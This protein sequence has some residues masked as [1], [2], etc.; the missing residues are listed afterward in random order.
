MAPLFSDFDGD[1]KIDCAELSSDGRF[2]QIRLTLGKSISRPLSFESQEGD[3]GVLLSSDLDRD[4]DLDL[5]WVSQNSPGQVV[6]WL[7]DGHGNFFRDQESV[8]SFDQVQYL[9]AQPEST[10]AGGP[11]E[12]NRLG[13]LQSSIFA[14]VVASSYSLFPPTTVRPPLFLSTS[15]ASQ[16]F[17]S[18]V[19]KRGPPAQYS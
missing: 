11:E 2:K 15:T 13:T 12:T 10:V 19:P 16:R 17:F 9:L 7:G 14:G 6:A 5:V 18:A 4:G 8:Y 3:R 1:H